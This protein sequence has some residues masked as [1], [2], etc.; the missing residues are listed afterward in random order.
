[1]SMY[2]IREVLYALRRCRDMAR[3][4][5]SG[6]YI[7]HTGML[8]IAVNLERDIHWCVRHLAFPLACSFFGL[9]LDGPGLEWPRN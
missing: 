5:S 4:L 1:M 8:N 3:S 2:D 6:D 7:G 9:H